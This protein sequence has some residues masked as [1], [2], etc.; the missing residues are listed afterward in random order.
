VLITHRRRADELLMSM[1]DRVTALPQRE[2]PMLA[3]DVRA[4]EKVG[5][6]RGERAGALSRSERLSLLAVGSAFVGMAT[7]LAV[8]VP[9]ERHPSPLVIAFYIVVYALVS[10]VEFEIFTGGAVPTELVLVPLLFVLPLD[11]AAPA[12]A[13]G[14]IL[15]SL[16]DWAARRI[17]FERAALNLIGSCHVLGPVLVLWLSSSRVVTWSQWPIYAGAL[18]AQFA[19]ELPSIALAERIARRIRFRDL[20]PHILRTQLVDATL[21]PVGLLLAF[22]AQSQPYTVVLVLPLVWLLSVFARERRARI[23]NAIELSAAYRGTAYLLGDVVEADDPDTGRH[24]RDVVALSLA[25]ADRLGLGAQERRDTEFAALLHD[26]GKIRVPSEIVN[27]PGALTA[28]ERA[29]VELHTIEGQQMLERVGGLLASVGRIVRSCH[30][31]WDGGGYPDGLTGEEIPRVA[32]I[33]A[34]CDA[35]SAMTSDRPY[36]RALTQEVA[37]AGLRRTAGTQF[38][39]AVVEALIAMIEDER[40]A[41]RA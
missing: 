11:L 17:P 19:V 37:I 6:H 28:E 31:H 1:V 35:Y 12:V 32:R 40:P 7:A 20:A 27:K 41:P 2:P 16:V 15:G 36:R 14:L 4:D 22:A 29:V 8:L 30:E 13:A 9:T 21:A 18:L 23:D 5:E 25:V 39:P 38:E 26:V 33:V 10:R 34:C 24:S 3:F